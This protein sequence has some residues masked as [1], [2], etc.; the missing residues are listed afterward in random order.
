VNG[1]V[2]ETDANDVVLEARPFTVD[3]R[4]SAGELLLLL[5]LL[6]L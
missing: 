6:L 1:C 4:T 3:S 5:L 2:D